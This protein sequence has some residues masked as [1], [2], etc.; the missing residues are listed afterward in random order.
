MLGN[1]RGPLQG[2]R[3]TGGIDRDV[4]PAGSGRNISSGDR[5]RLDVVLT[6]GKG[7]HRCGAACELP[8]HVGAMNHTEDAGSDGGG[9]PCGSVLTCPWAMGS[10]RYCVW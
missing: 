3:M 4:G 8:G 7:Q 9:A 10:R 6:S 5:R 2:E 1:D